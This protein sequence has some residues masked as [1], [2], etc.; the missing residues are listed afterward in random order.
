M[1]SASGLSRRR[2]ATSSSTTSSID[3]DQQPAA[4]SAGGPTSPPH[5]AG[6]GNSS[7]T[8]A[9][10][11]FAGGSKIAFDPREVER[12]DEEARVGGRPPLLTILEEVLLLGLKDKQV[13]LCFHMRYTVLHVLVVT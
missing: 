13:S 4:S 12:E 7:T 3:D 10:S 2:V 9:G 8:H 6:N 1:S 11:A 5:T